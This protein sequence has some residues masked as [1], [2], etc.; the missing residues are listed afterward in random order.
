MKGVGGEV[1]GQRD[2]PR[3]KT[4][5][6]REGMLLVVCEGLVLKAPKILKYV[7]ALGLDGLGMATAL[8]KRVCER[9]R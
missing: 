3:V 9:D 5:K 8:R 4:N 6:V 2:L 1:T 7:D